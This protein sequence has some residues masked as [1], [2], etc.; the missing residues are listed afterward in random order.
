MYMRGIKTFLFLVL[1]IGPINGQHNDGQAAVYNMATSAVIGGI[2]AM[3]NK[4]QGQKT[5]KVLFKGMAQGALGG[6]LVFESKRLLRNLSLK[7]DYTY[8]WPS[9]ILNS[10]GNSMVMNAASNRDFWERWYLNIGFGHF[11]YDLKRERRLSCR[12]MPITLFGNIY[13]FTQGKL[14]VSK[15]IQTGVFIFKSDQLFSKNVQKED[16]QV[17]GQTF[18]NT[19]WYSLNTTTN[20]T[21]YQTITHETSTCFSV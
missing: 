13:G 21:A 11:E 7:K 18:L 17:N 16:I 4:K 3:I 20:Q 5:H 14:D 1:A 10:A 19:I 15:S 6:Y 12:I 9:R 2:G 8:V